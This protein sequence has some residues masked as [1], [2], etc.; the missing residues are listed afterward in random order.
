V[1][2]NRFGALVVMVGVLSSSVVWGNGLEDATAP[3]ATVAADASMVPV[4]SAYHPQPAAR[5]A[6]LPALYA[7]LGAMQVWDLAS[8]SA[9]IKAGA[10]EANPAAAPFATNRGAMIGLK[11][12][13]TASTI[14]F[15]E[16]A[17][18]KNKAAAVLMMVAVNGAMASVALNNMRNARA[19]AIR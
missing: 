15:A 6:V 1:K 8:T 18:K 4:V 10:H 11:A 7:T 17:W 19:L 13:T 5:P 9:A 16:R 12:A 2:L 14:L 3:D